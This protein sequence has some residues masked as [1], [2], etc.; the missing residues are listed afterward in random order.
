MIAP[1]PELLSQIAM[2]ELETIT[3]ALPPADLGTV[4]SVVDVRSVAQGSRVGEIELRGETWPVFCPDEELHGAAEMM[5]GRRYCA[6]LAG[7]G[8][9]FG[10]ICREVH[11]VPLAELR[12]HRLPAC[13]RSGDTPLK[14]LGV[15]RERLVGLT[16]ATALHQVLSSGSDVAKPAPMAGP[17][18]SHLESAA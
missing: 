18:G 5:P 12:T 14:G 7:P 9:L 4:E 16:T 13:M 8:G 2:I 6:M 3:L 1:Q 17:V 10:V 11:S 15:W